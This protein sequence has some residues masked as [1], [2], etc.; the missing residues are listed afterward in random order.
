MPPCIV[1]WAT[2]ASTMAYATRANSGKQ[3]LEPGQ[4]LGCRLPEAPAKETAKVAN[5]HEPK[6][7]PFFHYKSTS[8]AGSS[9]NLH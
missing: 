1:A 4:H 7:C 8:T 9:E 6:D 2:Q 3:I 5:L